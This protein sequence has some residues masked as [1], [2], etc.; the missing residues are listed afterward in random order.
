MNLSRFIGLT[1]GILAVF[2]IAIAIFLRVLG[3]PYNLVVSFAWA[4]FFLF[5]F[6]VVFFIFLGYKQKEDSEEKATD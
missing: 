4:G 1:L 2:A 6:G 3:S 5:I